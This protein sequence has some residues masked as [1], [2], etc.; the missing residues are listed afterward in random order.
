MEAGSGEL[1]VRVVRGT[2]EVEITVLLA[3]AG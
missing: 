1:R 3:A 2:E